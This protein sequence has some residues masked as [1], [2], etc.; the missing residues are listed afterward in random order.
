MLAIAVE[1]A[2]VC[3][4]WAW[5]FQDSEDLCAVVILCGELQTKG[6]ARL[7]VLRPQVP[8]QPSQVSLDQNSHLVQFPRVHLS[9]SISETWKHKPAA[10]KAIQP[11]V[12]DLG[13]FHSLLFQL[14]SSSLALALEK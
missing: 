4:N 14:I 6:L 2:H 5:I 3:G 9:V 13:H 10:H 11:R 8:W 12:L 7:V 1:T